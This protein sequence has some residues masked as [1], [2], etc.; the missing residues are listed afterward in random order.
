MATRRR[1]ASHNPMG[2]WFNMAS[3]AIDAS[4][5][6]PLRLAKIAAGGAAATREANGMV[7][8]KVMAANRAAITLATGGS[9]EKVVRQ[10]GSKVRANRK[11][12]SK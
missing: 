4:F 8:E 6:I 9:P 5:V 12:L 2:L 1:Q 3:M 10:Y 7:T 11:R